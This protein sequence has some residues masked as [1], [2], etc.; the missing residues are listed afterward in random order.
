MV[1]SKV[2]EEV[3][4]NYGDEVHVLRNDEMTNTDGTDHEEAPCDCNVVI[5]SVVPPDVGTPSVILRPRRHSR[6]S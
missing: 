6:A 2:E 1:F 3:S 4:L 5:P